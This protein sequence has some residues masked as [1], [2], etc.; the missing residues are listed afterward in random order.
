MNDT[1]L[2]RRISLPLLTLYGLGTI[3]GAGIYV[4]IGEV[5]LRADRLA[6]LSF[7]AAALIAALTAYSFARLA[8]MFPKSAGEAVYAYAAFNNRI[9]TV[10]VSFRGSESRKV[11][12]SSPPLSCLAPSKQHLALLED[13]DRRFRQIFIGHFSFAPRNGILQSRRPCRTDRGDGA[14]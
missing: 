14:D 6:P 9:I 10:I 13:N 11:P 2:A 5:A 7:I 12:K 3:L 8:S 4:L 1:S